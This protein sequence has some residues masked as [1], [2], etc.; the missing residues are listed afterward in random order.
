MSVLTNI[1]EKIYHFFVKRNWN[2]E[3]E[4]ET[5]VTKHIIE[6]DKTRYKHWILFARLNYHYRILRKSTHFLSEEE[7]TAPPPERQ[8]LLYYRFKDKRLSVDELCEK[9]EKYDIVSFD[10]FDTA[11]YRKVNKPDWIFH[12]MA[13]EMGV[14]AFQSMRKKAENS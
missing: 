13:L 7:L 3:Q 12:I 10:I 9:T 5:Y 14:A 11:I 2:I 4:Y 8:E 1:K 6:H